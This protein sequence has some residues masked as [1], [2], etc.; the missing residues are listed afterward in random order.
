[1]H[2]LGREGWREEVDIKVGVLSTS[3][4][5]VSSPGDQGKNVRP[6]QLCLHPPQGHREQ[7]MLSLPRYPRIPNF[8]M[9]TLLSYQEQNIKTNMPISY[10]V[11]ETAPISTSVRLPK[12]THS[13]LHP[14]FLHLPHLQNYGGSLTNVPTL[15]APS[16]VA[17]NCEISVR[18]LA[19]VQGINNRNIWPI[20]LR[21]NQHSHHACP[22]SPSL[23]SE[24]MGKRHSIR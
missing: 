8:W 21:N 15:H 1:M 18:N 16:T 13:P 20:P 17:P 19:Q 4:Q 22:I 23:L 10:Q 11:G 24:R 14:E 3:L 9:P 6:L 7:C 2:P 12:R 5:T